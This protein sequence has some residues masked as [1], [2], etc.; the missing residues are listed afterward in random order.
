MG[1]RLMRFAYQLGPKRTNVLAD[2]GFAVGGMDLRWRGKLEM[3]L[4]E[5]MQVMIARLERLESRQDFTDG[6]AGYGVDEA[7]AIR[8]QPTKL[9]LC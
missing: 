4:N 2:I 7:L 1:G 8:K 5:R 3:L 9:D 6:A